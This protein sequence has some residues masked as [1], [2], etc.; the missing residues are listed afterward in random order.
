MMLVDEAAEWGEARRRMVV[1]LDYL[2]EEVCVEFGICLPEAERARLC[3]AAYD[4]AAALTDAILRAE[5]LAPVYHDRL[6]RKVYDRVA[7]YLGRATTE[8]GA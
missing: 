2:L 5:G 4:D 6:R 7:R 1:D 8:E 3:E